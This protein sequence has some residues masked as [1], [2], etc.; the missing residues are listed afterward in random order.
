LKTSFLISLII[1][2]SPLDPRLIQQHK[3]TKIVTD[4]RCYKWGSTMW[5]RVCQAMAYFTKIK[6]QV[7]IHWGQEFTLTL[8][9]IFWPSYCLIC[10][11]GP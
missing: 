7:L 5:I 8:S 6:S 3:I 1:R 9:L 11:C 10:C 2:H 4:L